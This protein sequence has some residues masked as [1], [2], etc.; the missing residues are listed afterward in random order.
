MV[1]TQI[2]TTNMASMRKQYGKVLFRAH[3]SPYPPSHSLQAAHGIESVSPHLLRHTKRTF[4]RRESD[5]D[6]TSMKANADSTVD[7]QAPPPVQ[8]ARTNN[9]GHS[10]N[11]KTK[12]PGFSTHVVLPP[13]SSPPPMF[14]AIP[15][16][17]SDQSQVR[18]L[19]DSRGERERLNSLRSTLPHP[20]KATYLNKDDDRYKNEIAFVKNRQRHVSINDLKKSMSKG[21]KGSFRRTRKR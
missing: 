15:I 7:Y 14:E 11:R 12:D 20:S 17:S 19:I 13:P 5:G 8:H 18:K 9:V 10:K 21:K 1:T 3:M 6:T 4:K 2:S 16:T